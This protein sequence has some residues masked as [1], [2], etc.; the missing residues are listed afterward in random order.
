VKQ[1]D[2]DCILGLRW[3]ATKKERTDPTSRCMFVNFIDASD[4]KKLFSYRDILENT[5]DVV[6]VTGA[7]YHGCT[8]G[9][10]D[11]LYK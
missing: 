1:T 6:I 9:P 10:N 5:Q 7:S 4:A 8:L 11:Y 3:A 2:T